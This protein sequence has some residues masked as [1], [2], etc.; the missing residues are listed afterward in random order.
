[1][2]TIKTQHESIAMEVNER[3]FRD[4]MGMFATGVTIITTTVDGEDY[5]TTA[6]AVTSV[7]TQPP[8]LL[9]CLNKMSNTGYAVSRSSSFVINIL[10]EAQED[11]ARSFAAKGGNKF[12][13]VEVAHTASGHAYLANSLAYIECSV[14]EAVSA[15]THDVFIGKV[16]T[17]GSL[18]ADNP[19]VFYRGQFGGFQLP[20]HDRP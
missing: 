2:T 8:M 1:M 18:I 3:S 4:L 6:N 17:M 7:S 12:E 15:A 19:L 20:A 14:E 16:H 11:L 10:A 13:N 5:G 9:T